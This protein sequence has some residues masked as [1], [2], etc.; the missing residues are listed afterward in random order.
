LTTSDTNGHESE[1]AI[2]LD[3]QEKAPF[4]FVSIRGNSLCIE[5]NSPARLRHKNPKE[6]RTE[7]T[8]EVSGVGRIRLLRG[9]A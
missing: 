5:L 1:T 4:V 2:S 3:L 6:P 7:R 9:Y 8:R